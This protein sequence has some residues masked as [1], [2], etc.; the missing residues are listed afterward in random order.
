MHQVAVRVAEHLHLDVLGSGDVLLEEDV[1][2]S[3]RAKRF[4]EHFAA[5]DLNRDG[6]LSRVEVSEKMPRLLPA[7]AFMDEDRDGLLT[8]DDV[9]RDRH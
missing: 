1:A 8:R 7:F 3:E 2:L 5:A 6:K 4:D 9:R